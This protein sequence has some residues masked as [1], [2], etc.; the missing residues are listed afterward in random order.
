MSKHLTLSTDCVEFVI[1]VDGIRS[2]MMP[3]SLFFL[4]SPI[5]EA[6]SVHSSLYVVRS[7]CDRNEPR[8]GRVRR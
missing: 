3:A 8:V 7:G 2:G 5:D 1:F 4:E 6:P